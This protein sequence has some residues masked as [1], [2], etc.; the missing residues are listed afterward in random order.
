MTTTSPR[1]RVS[2]KLRADRVV[3]AAD[4]RRVVEI[5]EVAADSSSAA[6]KV[7]AADGAMIAGRS[8]IVFVSRTVC[9]K[10]LVLECVNPYSR[11]RF[12]FPR[13]GG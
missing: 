5:V 13:V 8:A 11:R 9:S 3:V 6:A 2:R 10:P 1:R 12:R 4:V 7:A